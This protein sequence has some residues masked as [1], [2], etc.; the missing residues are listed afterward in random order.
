M[1]G[2]GDVVVE[3]DIAHAEDHWRRVRDE[4]CSVHIAAILYVGKER[5]IEGCHIEAG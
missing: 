3:C 5:D 4:D 1:V 2:G